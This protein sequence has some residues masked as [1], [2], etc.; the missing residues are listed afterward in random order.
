M[1]KYCPNCGVKLAEKAKYCSECGS[2]IET[3]ETST[4]EVP[5]A[6]T[7]VVEKS[8]EPKISTSLKPSGTRSN[9]KHTSSIML[10]V[11]GAILLIS[12]MWLFSFTD[13]VPHYEIISG[14]KFQS[15]WDTIHPYQIPAGVLAVFGVCILFIAWINSVVTEKQART[16]GIVQQIKEVVDDKGKTPSFQTIPEKSPIQIENVKLTRTGGRAFF[17]LEVRNAC[18]KTATKVEVTPPFGHPTLIDLPEGGL[19]PNQTTKHTATLVGDYNVG[20]TY[21]MVVKAFYSDGTTSS[22]VVSVRCVW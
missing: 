7:Q 12:G 3:A 19:K 13:M 8:S 15:G 6:E 18:D 10:F 1:P 20:N 14:F 17:M 22:V 5:T 21:V 2:K 4:P 9:Q 11:F 16:E